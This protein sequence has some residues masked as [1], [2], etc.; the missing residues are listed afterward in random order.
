MFKT[1]GGLIVKATARM[2]WSKVRP[3]K[4]DDKGGLSKS[5]IKRTLLIRKLE[6]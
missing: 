4:F 3:G 5:C 6:L 1:L 2:A